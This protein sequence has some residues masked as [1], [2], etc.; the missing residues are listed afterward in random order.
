MGDEDDV[1]GWSWRSP[2]LAGPW[3]A[4]GWWCAAGAQTYLGALTCDASGHKRIDGVPCRQVGCGRSI[5]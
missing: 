3:C 1:T 2:W 4:S 5:Y